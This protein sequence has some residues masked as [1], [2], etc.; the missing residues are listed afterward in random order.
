M[1]YRARV[2]GAS[3]EIQRAAMGGTMV[4]CIFP[5]KFTGDKSIQ[6]PRTKEQ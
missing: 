1:N 4:T 3:L 2:I 6:E 5:V